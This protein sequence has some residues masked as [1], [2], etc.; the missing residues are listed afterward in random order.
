MR[1]YKREDLIC[2]SNS[3]V[4]CGFGSVG[5]KQARFLPRSTQHY[6]DRT[7]QDCF[8]PQAINVVV[9]FKK[10]GGCGP[11]FTQFDGTF[12]STAGQEPVACGKL[13]QLFLLLHPIM[14]G[15]AFTPA[16]VATNM[17]QLLS[18]AHKDTTLM[19]RCLH[20]LTTAR[21]TVSRKVQ[22]KDKAW[23]LPYIAKELMCK[24]MNPRKTDC[25]MS[26]LATLLDSCDMSVLQTRFR[27]IGLTCDVRKLRL[28]NQ[29]RADSSTAGSAETFLHPKGDI[30]D[31][32]TFD[33]FG[34]EVKHGDTPGGD[35]AKAKKES[36]KAM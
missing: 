4:P 2:E 3:N 10:Q 12:D 20:A 15:D 31:N 33:N 26:F 32:D 22:V 18:A 23:L 17:E 24:A 35:P 28:A 19:S 29:K 27:Q 25:A 36:A 1:S 7:A 11:E 34:F 13:V 30:T 8:P 5:E 6:L 14:K 16:P 9:T 21:P